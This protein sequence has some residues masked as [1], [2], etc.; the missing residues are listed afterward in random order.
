MLELDGI[1]VSLQRQHAANLLIVDNT[2]RQQKQTT[3][4]GTW[5]TA[6]R[7]ALEQRDKCT[8]QQA[9]RKDGRMTEYA[10]LYTGS[11]IHGPWPGQ[12]SLQIA[13]KRIWEMEEY[14]HNDDVYARRQQTLLRYGGQQLFVT[15]GRFL[16][17]D[18]E[19]R[20]CPVCND[21]EEIEGERHMVQDCPAYANERDRFF[22]QL[23]TYAQNTEWSSW[24]QHNFTINELFGLIMGIFPPNIR[25]T[26]KQRKVIMS[27]CRQFISTAMR[28]RERLLASLPRPRGDRSEVV[29]HCPPVEANVQQDAVVVEQEAA[30]IVDRE[31]IPDSN[32]S[33]L[34]LSGSES[35][36]DGEDVNIDVHVS[37]H[38]D[39]LVQLIVH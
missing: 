27:Y 16:G 35:G 30:D 9:I 24:I 4:A 19:Q 29:D 23:E 21:D 6:V 33:T 31:I 37:V 36:S 13:D 15:R 20:Q 1:L 25:S 34:V 7:A 5:D 12:R 8:W 17:L 39:V 11:A 22:T 3:L 14:L 10:A 2:E 32:D 18:R 26:L 38:T 28:R